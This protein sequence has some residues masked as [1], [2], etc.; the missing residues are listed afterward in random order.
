[1]PPP[2]GRPERIQTPAV[3]TPGAVGS[4]LPTRW[5][6]LVLW[7]F[8]VLLLLLLL[9]LGYQNFPALPAHPLA[10][11]AP[12]AGRRRRGAVLLVEHGGLALDRLVVLG[13]GGGLL[14][15]TGDGPGRGRWGLGAAHEAGQAL[16]P[17]QEGPFGRS[18]LRL[19]PL[20]VLMRTNTAQ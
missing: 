10:G 4:V 18:S 7:F 20:V 1:V 3:L 14:V 15:A 19:L 17:P 8:W 12:G 9:L 5:S 2:G 6:P 11:A 16:A 13:R